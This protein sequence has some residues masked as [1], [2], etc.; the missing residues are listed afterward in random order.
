V[1]DVEKLQSSMTALNRISDDAG[2]GIAGAGAEIQKNFDKIEK[3]Q[4]RLSR[5]KN[6]ETKTYKKLQQ[7]ILD[8]ASA[9]DELNSKTAQ[10][11]QRQREAQTGAIGLNRALGLAMKNQAS[12][13]ALQ[14]LADAYLRIGDLRKKLVTGGLG[15]DVGLDASISQLKE[16]ASALSL[17]ANNVK[18]ASADFN[19]FSVAVEGANKKLAEAEQQRFR[20]IAF[21][22]SPQAQ[23]QNFGQ[24][25][26][27]A[28]L[29]GSRKLI[30]SAL[31][32][33]DTVTRSEAAMDSYL[34][35]L[36]RLRS[37]VPVIS[38]EYRALEERIASVREEMSGFGLRGQSMKI[39]PQLGPASRLDD[40]KSIIKKQ[41]Y[42]D[43]IELQLDRIAALETRVD[44]AFLSQNQKL[45]LRQ[46]LDKATSSLA[47]RDLTAS[48]R[49]TAE[50][51]RQRMSLERL[52]RRGTPTPVT[53]AQ[54]LA[55]KGINW[56]SALA[57]V[58][59]L[60]SGV[61]TKAGA[62]QAGQIRPSN[63]R[64]TDVSPIDAPKR[65]ANILASGLLLQEK[66]A[67]AQAKGVEIGDTLVKL[68]NTL[69][70]AK[71][72]TFEISAK[73]LD[74][75][76]EELNGTRQLLA[77]EKQRAANAQAESKASE[78]LA[79]R[80]GR[81]QQRDTGTLTSI[82]GDLG[83][84]DTAAKVFRGGRSGEQALSNI[85]GAFNASVG[86]KATG[87]GAGGLKGAVS[88]AAETGASVVSTFADKLAGGSSSAAAAATK[89]ASA[90]TKA[91][92]K[93]FGRNSPP[94]FILML[95]SDIIN[96][97]TSR[98]EQGTSAIEA[99]FSKA[100]GAGA[101]A[102][103]KAVKTAREGIATASLNLPTRNP[104][105]GIAGQFDFAVKRPS[106]GANYGTLSQSIADL[107][108]DSAKYRRRID[109]VGLQNF[110][111]E[112][113]RESSAR[114]TFQ[115][116]F[117][118]MKLERIFRN[119]P[120]LLEKQIDDAF[121]KSANKFS[122][123]RF[124]TAPMSPVA[125]QAGESS[126][127]NPG[128]LMSRD[129]RIRGK[130]PTLQSAPPS[131]PL[132]SANQIQGRGIG[133]PLSSI[134]AFGKTQTLGSEA[135]AAIG[136]PLEKLQQALNS[137]TKPIRDFALSVQSAANFTSSAVRSAGGG[138]RGP[139]PPAPPA[140]PDPGDFEGRVNA[141]RG[142]AD[143]LLGLKDLADM[144]GA[145]IKQLQLLSQALSE[146]REGVKMTDASF[147]QLTKVLNKVDDQI[148]RR[149]TG[150][151]FLT[152]RFGQRGGQAVGEGLIGG[153]FPLLFGQGAGAAAGGG[154]G[155][156]FGG[157]AGGTLGFGLSLA[158]TAIGSQVDMLM[159]ATQDT[160][161]M[162][163]DLVGNFEQIKDSGLLA[164]RGQEKLIG[165]LIE[166]GNKTAAYS[167]IQGELNN[168]LGVDGATKLREAADAGDRLKRAMAD[169]GVQIQL[170][171][172]GPLTDIL[173]AI[174]SG[175]E[176]SG[177]E[178]RFENAFAA[179]TPEARAAANRQLQAAAEKAGA[180]RG[181]GLLERLIGRPLGGGGAGSILGIPTKDLAEIT[182]GLVRSTPAPQ[183]K[184]QEQR[185]KAIRDAETRRDT[186]QRDLE[187]FNKRNEGAD[188]GR[189]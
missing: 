86:G 30:A 111:T 91:I 178:K 153:A 106:L 158:G 112:I 186:A 122:S 125:G 177:T 135:G 181:S 16:Q 50:I 100:F 1:R 28:N 176:R 22:L 19:R 32:M 174:A 83:R 118:E 78:Q 31:A 162:L 156:F 103:G 67:G 4:Q 53:E 188:I 75:L 82:L 149:D 140:G 113:L 54:K 45:E 117:P 116:V 98:L 57:Q 79:K 138:G 165:N 33:G 12:V 87:T 70:A 80:L 49:Q 81:G 60:S 61:S 155:G 144:S 39:Q 68:Q 147:D 88:G 142:N 114:G 150:A 47:E 145:S 173:N 139:N 71:A 97:T 2:K 65:L 189:S 89:F 110:P 26:S 46:K 160:G 127:L 104:Q 20:A 23:R 74:I 108:I 175:L 164:S 167:I 183:L 58:E 14:G 37:L 92:N 143:Q 184:P 10:L 161:N 21:G 119:L 154:L 148:A 166:A 130:L 128:I 42:Y 25:T 77:L 121:V 90:A 13:N 35:Y 59:E 171:V 126:I 134:F 93:V 66:L 136:S 105:T 141:A 69:N 124:V 99:A 24:G 17:V 11:T 84:A 151:D 76:D 63:I 51:D 29:A 94:K 133:S 131:N 7:D 48:K 102:V 120:G 3:A 169:L 44:Q 123:A 73:S 152:R 40:P 9:I 168:K 159:Q 55:A 185:D 107:T 132:F 101:N 115:D 34:G 95:I 43:K 85:I 52:N 172:A 96:A 137:A 157:L 129:Q 146:T 64:T 56:R 38:N 18:I 36:E 72:D 5:L 109:A 15:K 180:P 8:A 6:P 62:G 27:E 187:V 182:A 163:R 170:L 179:A 41:G